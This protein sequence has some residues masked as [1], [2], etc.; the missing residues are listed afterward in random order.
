MLGRVA[1][2]IAAALR[3]SRAVR[4]AQAA[5][6]LALL[7]WIVRSLDARSWNAMR[8]V[9]P[10]TLGIGLLLFSSAQIFGG[11]RL[12]LLLPQRALW[13][14]ALAATWIGYFWGNFLPSTVGGDVVRGFRLSRA[15]VRLPSVAAVLLLDRVLNLG[16]VVLILI[17]SGLALGAPLGRHFALSAAAPIAMAALAGVA[18]VV[19]IGRGRRSVAPIVTATLAPLALLARSRLR[20]LA[21]AAMS[22]VSLGA[23]IGAQWLLARQLGMSLGLVQLANII[24]LVTIIALLPVSLNGLGVQEAS[25]AVLLT[26][27]GA[28]IELALSFSL[29]ARLLIVG[30]GA[31]GGLVAV[32]DRV[33]ARPRPWTG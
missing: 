7:L 27:A 28:P 16:A 31:I 9:G 11:L 33:R 18:L 8:S 19:W 15:G 5:V 32:A 1:P 24:C 21:V 2:K 12:A 14:E 29:L 4:L 17:A 6:T 22:F 30:T 20:L 23:A 25:F 3:R 10:A 26:R 13:R